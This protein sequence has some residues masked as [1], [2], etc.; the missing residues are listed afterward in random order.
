MSIAFAIGKPNQ[1]C[2]QKFLKQNNQKS[3]R[4]KTPPKPPRK[5][6]SR[7]ENVSIPDQ[8]LPGIASIPHAQHPN[9]KQIS[10]K[11]S[12][13]RLV[14]GG[15]GGSSGGIQEARRVMYPVEASVLGGRDG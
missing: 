7:P 9:S 4:T 3:F 2:A 11:S 12:L 8:S 14:R 5:A 6:P 15:A 10:K 1:A 13:A